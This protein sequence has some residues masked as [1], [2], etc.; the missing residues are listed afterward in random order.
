MFYL[1]IN[2]IENLGKKSSE[3]IERIGEVASIGKRAFGKKTS[4]GY[5]EMY[6]S[7]G[8]CSGPGPSPKSQNV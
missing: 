7:I 4:N 6:A 2:L 8:E 1:V 3:C 5:I